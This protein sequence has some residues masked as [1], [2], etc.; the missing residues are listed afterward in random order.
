MSFAHSDKPAVTGKGAVSAAR[1]PAKGGAKGG[2]KRV[3]LALSD[4]P[5]VTGKE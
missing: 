4:K 3:S 2:S 1:P 5:A